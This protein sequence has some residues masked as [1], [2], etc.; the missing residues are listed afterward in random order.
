MQSGK[1]GILSNNHVLANVN[2]ANVGDAIYQPGRADGGTPAH[3]IANLAAYTQI[4]FAG[5]P[6]SA[7]CAWAELIDTRQYN[8][9]SITDSAGLTVASISTTTP[10]SLMPLDRVIK[11][12]RSTGYTQGEVTAVFA[13]NLLVEMGSGLTARFANVVQVESLNRNRFSDN[14][15]SGSVILTHDGRPG[16]LLFA[17]TKTGGL[18]LHGITFANPLDIVE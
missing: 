7:D 10:A 13:A 5:I 4:F 17:G 9:A 16:G 15:D 12:G 11:I 14:G 2:S 18:G 1:L 3:A 6:N 8:P